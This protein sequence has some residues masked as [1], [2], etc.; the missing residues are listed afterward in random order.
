MNARKDNAPSVAT[1]AD[2]EVITPPHPLRL[3]ITQALD[4][5]DDPV[6]RAEAALA[7]LSTE[8]A[9][10]MQADCERLE[11]ARQAVMREGFT[12][13]TH[14][15]LEA[16]RDQRVSDRGRRPGQRWGQHRPPVRVSW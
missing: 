10:W 7:Q 11:T 6:A 3:T 5:Q 12:E 9:A 13:K 8:F 14:A 2:H 15:E 1:F 4:A 16:S